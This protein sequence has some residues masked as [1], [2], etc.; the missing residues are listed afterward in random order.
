MKSEVPCR[1]PRILPLIGHGDD[2]GVIEV[3]P[4]FVAPVAP[5]GWR[6]RL[7]RIAVDPFVLDIV[8]VLLRPEHAR[9]RLAHHALGVGAEIAWYHFAIELVGFAQTGCEHAIE[10]WTERMHLTRSLFFGETQF[11]RNRLAGSNR[12]LVVGGGF[13]PSVAWVHSILICVHYVI[14][15]AVFRECRTIGS[16]VEHAR[17][18][19]IVSKEKL[20]SAFAI[21]PTLAIAVMVNVNHRLAMLGTFGKLRAWLI[22]MPSP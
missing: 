16:V 20:R 6:L 22:A 17:V 18:G 15:D 4:I 5:L 7:S 8:V 21:E 9:E 1:V 19:L 10:L 2:V 3:S 14:V 11:H 13:R 12:Q